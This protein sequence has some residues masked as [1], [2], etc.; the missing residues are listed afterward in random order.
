VESEL[1]AVLEE[2]LPYPDQINLVR[3]GLPLKVA[4]A[5]ASTAK[6][7]DRFEVCRGLQV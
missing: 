1:I 7:K 4:L 5:A 2:A 3:L 6:G